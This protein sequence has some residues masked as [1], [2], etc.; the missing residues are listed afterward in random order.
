MMRRLF[1][2]R[3]GPAPAS[4]AAGAQL[5]ALTS[6]RFVAA[7]AVLVL[8]YRDLLGPLPAWLLRAIVGGQFGVTFFFVLSGFIL[9]YRYREWF[10]RGVSSAS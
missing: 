2:S 9:T 8:H 3:P 10:A 4:T 5:P 6:L 1:I 7:F